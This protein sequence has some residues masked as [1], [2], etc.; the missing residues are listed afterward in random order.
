MGI[1]N[2]HDYFYGFCYWDKYNT[3]SCDVAA[4]EV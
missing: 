2:R 4:V 1:Q 3:K